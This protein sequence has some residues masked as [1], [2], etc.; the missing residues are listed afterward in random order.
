MLPSIASG[1]IDIGDTSVGLVTIGMFRKF[2]VTAL[3]HYG[4]GTPRS[5]CALF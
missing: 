2:Q 5:A 1:N 3:H 4:T